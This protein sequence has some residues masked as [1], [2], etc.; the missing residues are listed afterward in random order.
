MNNNEKK[1]DIEVQPNASNELIASGA[2]NYSNNT[3]NSI[4]SN[5]Y[6]MNTSNKNK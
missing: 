5:N 4:E 2:T 3:T 1:M 6:Y